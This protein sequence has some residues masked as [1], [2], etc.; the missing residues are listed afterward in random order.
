MVMSYRVFRRATESDLPTLVE[1]RDSAAR[2]LAGA[3]IEQWRP[4]E[5][6]ADHFRAV[7][8]DGEVW[9]ATDGPGGRVV[10]AWEIWWEDERTWGP[11][12]APAGYIHRLMIDH[13]NPVRGTGRAMLTAA[14]ERIA[15]AGRSL[16][17][18]DCAAHNP[19]LR[20]YYTDAGY[21]EVGHQP[22]RLGSRY[23]V[24]L[25]EKEL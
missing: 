12:P 21:R 2:W 8:R 5:M 23:P 25:F 3:G 7:M 11:Q 17:R 15:A 24:T 18:L 6:T 22:H 14:E 9:V 1:L 19:R 10:G 20:R 16:A 4:G 13:E